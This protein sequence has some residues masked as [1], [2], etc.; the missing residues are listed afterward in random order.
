MELFPSWCEN[1]GTEYCSSD[2]LSYLE[3]TDDNVHLDENP[4]EMEVFH[5][6]WTIIQL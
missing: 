2:E 3:Y 4:D 6:L 1:N 5:T